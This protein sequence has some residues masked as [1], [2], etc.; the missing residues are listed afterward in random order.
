M[1]NRDLKESNRR[2]A[3]LQLLSD[4][5][6]RLWYRLITAVDDYGRLEADPEVV[7]TTCF[8][9]VPKGWSIAKVATCLQ[10][11]STLHPEGQSPLIALYQ[12]QAKTYLQVCTAWLY[13]RRRAEHSKYPEPP[14]HTPP[15]VPP[16]PALAVKRPHAP[17]NGTDVTVIVPAP[18]VPTVEDWFALVWEAFP[19]K[20]AKQEAHKKFRKLNP[21]ES[22]VQVM[23][24]A[25]K[26]A[27]GSDAWQREKGRFIP[28]LA[29][30]INQQRW[31]DQGVKGEATWK[32][33]FLEKS[34]EA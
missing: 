11:L 14:P 31:T 4:A 10:E 28:M 22:L 3:S 7:F 1:P 26:T 5:A 27:K 30:W 33:Q 23:L 18:K 24:A 16:V 19:R 21:S 8:Q 13:I 32:E 20:D 17:A 25:I 9:R 34:H 2:S 15:L 6:E 29:T 12:V